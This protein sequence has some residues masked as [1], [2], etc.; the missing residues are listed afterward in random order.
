M[1]R[2]PCCEKQHTNKGAWSKEEDERLIKYIK[3]HG[4]GCW[5]SLPKAA[6]LAR[7]GKSCRLRWI[8]YLR[9]DLKRGNFTRE[10]D[11]LIIRLHNEVGNKWSQ[12]A[13]QLK[14]RTDNEIKNYWNTHIKRKLYGRG[15]DPSTHKPL[16]PTTAAAGASAATSSTTTASAVASP[17]N[18]INKPALIPVVP[19]SSGSSVSHKSLNMKSVFPLFSFNGGLNE[20]L[21]V[22]DF[23]CGGLEKKLVVT[24]SGCGGVED[25]FSNTSSGVTLEETPY[26]HQINLE[27]SLAPPFQQPQLLSSQ[28]VCFC[29]QALG[30]RGNQPCCCINTRAIDA[31]SAPAPPPATTATGNDFC[32]FFG[33][34]F[35]N[36]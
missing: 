14:G 33:A 27:L 1:A 12:I 18:L 6:G 3:S 26:P 13:Q 8:N 24:D 25:S 7:C 31:A 19:T 32:R 15:V 2:S 23:G 30:L 35:I 5:R 29:N 21:V 4:E 28:G 20:K 22:T 17:T 16:K 34:G 36:F 11:E 9:P 10:E